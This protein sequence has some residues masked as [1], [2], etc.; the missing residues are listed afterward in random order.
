MATATMIKQKQSFTL[1]E[2]VTRAIKSDAKEQKVS[3]SALVDRILD[4]YLQSKK[5]KEMREGYKALREVSRSIVR[6]SK[7]LQKKVIPDY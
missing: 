7:S 3:R 4:E 6:A 5:E 2:S 1:S